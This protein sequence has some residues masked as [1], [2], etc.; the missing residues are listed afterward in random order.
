MGLLELLRFAQGEGL[1]GGVL[2][3]ISWSFGKHYCSFSICE[4]LMSSDVSAFVPYGFPFRS[5]SWHGVS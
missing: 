3:E 1:F 5:S 4:A 2:L